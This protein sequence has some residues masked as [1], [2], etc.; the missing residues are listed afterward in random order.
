[1]TRENPQYYGSA[2]EKA[3]VENLES[4]GVKLARKPRRPTVN[5]AGSS[6]PEPD[7]AEGKALTNRLGDKEIRGTDL[8][9]KGALEFADPGDSTELKRRPRPRE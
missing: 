1:M 2:L 6:K 4:W 9:A 8:G 5:L 7:V 3:A